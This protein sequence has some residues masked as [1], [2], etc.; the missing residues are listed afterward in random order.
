VVAPQRIVLSTARQM[1]QHGTGIWPTRTHDVSAVRQP[2]GQSDFR[3]PG[4]RQ[5]RDGRVKRREA[6]FEVVT[7]RSRPNLARLQGRGRARSAPLRRRELQRCHPASREDELIRAPGASSAHSSL[8]ASVS[9]YGSGCLT[10]ARPRSQTSKPSSGPLRLEDRMWALAIASSSEK[11]GGS[12]STPARCPS[13][14][15]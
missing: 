7:G 12:I 11:P 14:R 1:S 5:A 6:G 13:R 2:S 10:I 8:D 15:K 3:A 9:A 4:G